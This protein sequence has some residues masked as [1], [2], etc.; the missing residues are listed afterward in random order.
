M[1]QNAHLDMIPVHRF[2]G[3]KQLEAN[4][5]RK[6]WSLALQV[7]EVE[8]S[9]PIG[10]LE[11]LFDRNR[12][13]MSVSP[14]GLK[15]THRHAPPNWMWPCGIIVGQAHGHHVTIELPAIHPIQS[16]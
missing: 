3:P 5:S 13:Q 12:N 1:C 6:D 11:F 9:C 10:H 16:S 7:Q 14:Q 2:C 15:P 4:H 8:D